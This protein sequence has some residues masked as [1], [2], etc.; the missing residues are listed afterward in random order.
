[1]TDKLLLVSCC[2]PCSCGVIHHL[3]QKGIDF[4]VLFYNPNIVPFSEY[5]RR[6]K[7]NR[8]VCQK[9]KVPFIEL[10]YDNQRWCELTNGLENLPERSKRCDICFEMRLKKAFEYARQHGYNRVSS[11]LGFS[12]YKDFDQVNR[13]ALN[14]G[15]EGLYDPINWRK[16]GIQELSN[17]LKKELSLYNQNYC[18]CK[19]RKD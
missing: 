8:R 5:E 14:A 16:G 1:M 15:G 10:E 7:E 3:V 4:S 19:P 18:G 13:A 12:R 2:A 6:A 17:E 11:V 9:Y